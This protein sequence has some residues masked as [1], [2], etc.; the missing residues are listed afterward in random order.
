MLC[1]CFNI[2][3]GVRHIKGVD[4]GLADALSRD[5]YDNLGVV[6]WEVALMIYLLFFRYI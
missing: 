2:D 5:T 6:N 1:A 4:N 3:L